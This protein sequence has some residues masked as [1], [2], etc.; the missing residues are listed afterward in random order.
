MQSALSGCNWPCQ[1]CFSQ[2][3]SFSCFSQTAARSPVQEMQLARAGWRDETGER[4]KDKYKEGK[5]RRR[6]M[7]R[8]VWIIGI[9]CRFIH[10]VIQAILRS[11]LCAVNQNSSYIQGAQHMHTTRK[12]W[13]EMDNAWVQKCRPQPF[14]HRRD[15]V[16]YDR[17]HDWLTLSSIPTQHPI[18]W[19]C[20]VTL[21]IKQTLSA[22]CVHF[23]S[24]MGPLVQGNVHVCIFCMYCMSVMCAWTCTKDMWL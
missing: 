5:I 3:V 20:V 18:Y 22:R 7:E 24:L 15:S 6:E 13:W 1:N 8:R 19:N 9:L 21:L 4:I 12:A 17:W 14:P 10:K 11:V 16:R 23:H 2:T